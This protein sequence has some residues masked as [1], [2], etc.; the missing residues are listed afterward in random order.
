LATRKIAPAVRR[1]AGFNQHLVKPI[2]PGQVHD[3]IPGLLAA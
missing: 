3:A 1:P 2:D